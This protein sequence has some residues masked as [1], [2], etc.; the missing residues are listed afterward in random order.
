MLKKT[1]VRD[2]KNRVIGSVTTG[3]EGS[4][5]AVVR[6]ERDNVLGTTSERFGTTRDAHG[7]LVSLNTA[8]PG[9][10]IHRKK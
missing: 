10:L 4:F 8:D 5:E 6:D 1:Y 7:N 2:G 3:F 9:L